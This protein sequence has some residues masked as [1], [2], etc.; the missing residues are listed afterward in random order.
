MCSVVIQNDQSK[1]HF[2]ALILCARVHCIGR[3]REIYK[4][5]L[6]ICLIVFAVAAV[7]YI[8]MLICIV[9]SYEVYEITI[10][11]KFQIY[12]QLCNQNELFRLY[13]I[14]NPR[15]LHGNTF[16]HAVHGCTRVQHARN[17]CRCGIVGL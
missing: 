14:T 8:L 17:Y 6:P 12:M 1:P 5:A 9:V 2:C 11:E 15:F 7:C 3:E 10:G 16:L 4:A 13:W